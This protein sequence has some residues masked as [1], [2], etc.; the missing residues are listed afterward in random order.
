MKIR[1]YYKSELVQAYAPD[2][3]QGAALNRLALQQ[4]ILERPF[5]YSFARKCCQTRN[6]PLLLYRYL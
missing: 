1:P 5:G 6:P 3:S 4:A 2:I